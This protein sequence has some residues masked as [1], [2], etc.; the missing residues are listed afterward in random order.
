VKHERGKGWKT[1]AFSAAAKAVSISEKEVKT[2]WKKSRNIM[3]LLKSGGPG[4]LLRLGATI[5][6][7]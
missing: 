7:M 5:N 4:S 3:L 6:A 2:W 1:V